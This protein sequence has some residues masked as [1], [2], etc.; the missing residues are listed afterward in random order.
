[1]DTGLLPVA[2]NRKHGL[3][4]QPG[5]GRI[6]ELVMTPTHQ[7]CVRLSTL[8]IFFQHFKNQ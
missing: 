7:N 8:S 5:A 4:P 3:F 1:M 2:G 6:E